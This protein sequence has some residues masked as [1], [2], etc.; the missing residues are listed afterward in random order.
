MAVERRLTPPLDMDELMKLAGQALDMAGAGREFLQFAAVL[1][2]NEAWRETVA[3]IEYSRRLL[4]LPRCL[5]SMEA[6][7]DGRG[8]CRAKIDDIGLICAGCGSCLIHDLQAEAQRLGYAILVA[9]GSP[10]VMSMIRGGQISAVIGVSCLA[11]LKEVYPYM[12]AGAVP[13]LAVPLLRDGCKE[14]GVDADWV[15]EAIYLAKDGESSPPDPHLLRAEVEGWFAAPTIDE[16][17]GPADGQTDR[18]ARQWLARGGKRWRPFLAA[19]ASRSLAGR[20][21]PAVRKL[22]LA[23]ECFHKASLIHDDI[24]DGDAMRDGEPTLHQR[25]GLAVAI[26]VGD[27]LL[28]EGYRL[29]GE[30]AAPDS[31]KSAMFRCAADGHRRLCLGQGRE[32]LAVRDGRA[33]AA[34]EMLAIFDHK[35]SP[36]FEV[37][38]RLGALLAGADERLL[39]TL[40]QYSRA[41]GVAYQIKDDMDD[42][43]D[44]DWPAETPGRK[45]GAGLN[46]LVSIASAAAGSPDLANR[47]SREIRRAIEDTGALESAGRLLE[48]R[49]RRAMSCLAGLGNVG[50]KCLLR[51]VAGMIF[52]DL[53]RL[54]C[55]REAKAGRGGEKSD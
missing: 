23:V 15:F 29:I 33:P 19:C 16:L 49:R 25:Y 22:A 41:L 28:G 48:N 46:L 27:L 36:A 10:V 52:G 24:E 31:A 14:T 17:L 32:L 4:L 38:L 53:D 55:C 45:G 13:G 3:G 2:S 42:F 21:D 34:D 11:T 47:P 43:S 18:I 30:C 39:E 51:R 12:E 5:R 40:G 37:A 20:A 50:L 6:G 44:P 9:E 7:A 54:V 35:T 1:V 8:V 26:N